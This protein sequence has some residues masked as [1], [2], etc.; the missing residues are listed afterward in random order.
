MGFSFK[1]KAISFILSRAISVQKIPSV[2]TFQC[3][4]FK[5]VQS[6][7][8]FPVQ[9]IQSVGLFQ[10]KRFSRYSSSTKD[11][12][13]RDI[14]VQTI[15]K[16]SVSRAY[17]PVQKIP[18]VGTFQCKRFKKDAFSRAYIPVQ[19]MQSVGLFQ[20]GTKSKFSLEMNKTK[21]G[22]GE[23]DYKLQRATRRNS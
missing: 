14:P 10:Y 2:G 12:V 15:Q 13:S 8:A 7:R 3:K 6:V 16:C 18:S 19:K 20:Y 17:I 1:L 4:R 21:K 5:N 9:K 11:A 23:V 22:L